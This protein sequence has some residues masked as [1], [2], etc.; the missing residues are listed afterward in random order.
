M[1]GVGGL[2]GWRWIFI[3]EGILTV[4]VSVI[5]YWFISNYPDTASFLSEDERAHIHAR[6]KE[7]GDAADHE[8]FTWSAVWGALTDIK[9]WLYCF[10]FHTLSLPLY[11]FSLFLPTI[12][13]DLG[14]TAANSQLLTVPPY[15]LATI[16]TVFVAWWS[17]R[18]ERRAPFLIASSS[19][20]IIGYII[21]LANTD[22]DGRP[23]VSYL[24]TFFAAAG[25]YPSVALS[26]SWPANNVYGQTKRAVVNAMQI[27]I[28]NLGA[29]IGTQLYRPA[30][31]P[32]Y[33]LGHSFAL[34][35]LAANILVTLA[36]WWVLARENNR[37]DLHQTK[38]LGGSEDGEVK[39]ESGWPSGE[40]PNWRYNL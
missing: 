18:V 31:S 28:G 10:A 33:V 16:L 29:V 11:T 1:R 3:I 5:A 17:A 6:L 4:V 14:F 25:I 21:L 24:G 22:P 8:P 40:D 26:L 36:L 27:S 20:A 34:G 19:V 2:N 12:I 30:T 23:G 32:R 9:S 15:A 39:S 7:D 13:A 38:K 37:R 35:Y